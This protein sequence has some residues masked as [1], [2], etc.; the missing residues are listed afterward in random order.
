MF[1]RANSS[2]L[3]HWELSKLR[4]YDIIGQSAPFYNADSFLVS[5]VAW[6]GACYWVVSLKHTDRAIAEVSE[7]LG[8]SLSRGL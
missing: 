8:S 3:G 6:E 1:Q 7:Q 5:S 4:E 2:Q